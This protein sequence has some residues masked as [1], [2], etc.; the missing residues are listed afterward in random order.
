MDVSLGQSEPRGATGDSSTVPLPSRHPRGRAG[1]PVSLS[2]SRVL[3]SI[4]GPP[5][6]S[7]ASSPGTAILFTKHIVTTVPLERGAGA[8][9][10]PHGNAPSDALLEGALA[11]EPPGVGPEDDVW[12]SGPEQRAQRLSPPKPSLGQCLSGVTILREP[13]LPAPWLSE[14]QAAL[15]SAPHRA[16]GDLPFPRPASII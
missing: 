5:G 16:Q 3:G 13:L 11:R 14:T 6:K 7:P 9:L 10:N 4:S 8:M 15:S 2:G 1:C 12:G